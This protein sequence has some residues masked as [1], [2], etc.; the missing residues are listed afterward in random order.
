MNCS[1]VMSLPLFGINMKSIS[2]FEF[3]AP[4]KRYFLTKNVSNWRCCTISCLKIILTTCNGTWARRHQQ[5][6]ETHLMANG[7]LDEYFVS[8][9][10]QIDLW[11][12]MEHHWSIFPCMDSSKCYLR[13]VHF[14]FPRNSFRWTISAKSYHYVNHYVIYPLWHMSHVGTKM[15]D[16]PNWT[17]SVTAL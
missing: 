14:Y 17:I 3:V 10:R 9:T 1:F 8:K 12:D 4:E 5:E 13:S 7:N 15:E 11:S 2:I 6:M 16:S